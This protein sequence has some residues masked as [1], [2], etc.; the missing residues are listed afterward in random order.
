VRAGVV[1]AVLLFLATPV[2]AQT[3]VRFWSVDKVLRR[4]DGAWIHVGERRV[5]VHSDTTLCAGRGASIRRDGVR[6]W[7]RFVCTY[8]TFT[9]AGADR[10]VDFRVRVLGKTRYSLY[11]AHWVA[12]SR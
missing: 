4:L 6:R 5:R 3:S 9:K 7:R 12:A 11:D 8:T 1:L 10:D 2:A